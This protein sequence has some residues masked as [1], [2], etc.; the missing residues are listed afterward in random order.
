MDEDFFEQMALNT[1][2]GI[3]AGLKKNPIAN[4][5]VKTVIE[6]IVTDGCEILGVTPPT[7]P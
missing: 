1:V 2:L 5:K 7:L 4:P 6:H 3:F